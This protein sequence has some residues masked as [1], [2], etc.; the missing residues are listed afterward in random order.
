MVELRKVKAK[1]HLF[2]EASFPTLSGV[3][4]GK[5]GE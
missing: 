3:E 1:I 4:K 5:C 2:I